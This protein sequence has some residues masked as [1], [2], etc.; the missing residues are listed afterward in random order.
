MI[1][2]LIFDLI[3][4]LVSEDKF[5]SKVDEIDEKLIKKYKIPVD[6]NAF[7]LI[8]YEMLKKFD[9]LPDEEKIKPTKFYELCFEKMSIKVDKEILERMQEEFDETYINSITI[10]DGV[11]EL[12]KELKKKYK[13]FLVSD[14][15]K[16]RVISILNRFKMEEFFTEIITPEDYGTKRNLKPLEYIMEKYDLKANEIII[17]GDSEK[18]DII[19]AKKLSMFYIKVGKVKRGKIYLWY[20]SKLKDI[21]KLIESINSIKM[22]IKPQKINFV[23]IDDTFTIALLNMIKMI[24]N[25]KFDRVVAVYKKGLIPGVVLSMYLNTELSFYFKDRDEIY[26]KISEGKK[27]LFV[28][29]DSHSGSILQKIKKYNSKIAIMYVNYKTLGDVDFYGCVMNDEDT[30]FSYIWETPIYLAKADLVN[31]VTSINELLK[32]RGK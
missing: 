5:L 1:K 27:I 29:D 23:K 6:V 11:I 17:V 21:P 2:A 19:P 32:L 7:N 30:Y 12:L 14:T 4:T 3:G 28:D 26:P 31:M 8:K 22:E 15:I 25:E 9:E 16:K 20:A 13:L 10:N 24:G 18:D